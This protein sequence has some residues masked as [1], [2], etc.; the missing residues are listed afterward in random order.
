MH[1]YINRYFSLA[2]IPIIAAFFPYLAAHFFDSSQL[3]G[4]FSADTFFLLLLLQL[5]YGKIL[6]KMPLVVA[7]CI[8]AIITDSIDVYVTV[9]VFIVMIFVITFVPRTRKCLLPF[10]VIFSLLFIVADSGNFFYS[11]FVL[12]LPDVWNLA[13]FYWWGPVLFVVVPVSI[14]VL[15][16]LFVRRNLWGE[17]R[18]EIS[19][20][21]CY[22]LVVVALALNFGMN[23][24][25]D[26]QPIMD[27]AVK[28]WFWQVCTP[29]IIG[30]NT[31]LQEDTRANFSIWEKDVSVI[32]DFARPTVVVLVES[33]GVNKSVLYTKALLSSFENSNI[34]F[35][36]IYSREA[37]HTQGAE[38]EDF[39][40][41]GGVVRD[42]P[43][44]QKFKDHGLET[45]YIHGYDGSF[46]KRL[47]DYGKF[48]FDTLVF[49]KDLLNR[50][51]NNCAYG[52]Q[53]IC[54][55]AIIGFLDSLLTDSVP[56]FIYWTTLDAHPPYELTTLAEKAPE[57]SL[58][59]LS[60]VDCTYLTLQENTMKHLARLISKHDRYRFV[61]RGDH[62][63]MG[64]LEKTDFVQSFYFRWVPLIVVN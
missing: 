32:T 42:N 54:D 41:P 25:Q 35:L 49:K 12:T 43:I 30:Y 8:W 5:P 10:F 38:W 11:T 21:T 37:S 50:G 26:R 46:Y 29:G 33:F 40:T 36:G 53:G 52:F 13:R 3:H 7:G 55:S 19:H 60:D 24:L 63:P 27:F 20:L 17:S 31:F 15:Q 45:W 4:F 48:G 6:Y 59:D 39:G 62:R 2:I 56:K 28:K 47:D 51:L 58:L 22:I 1:K 9:A 61:I 16:V 34:R 57:C 18:F 44:P 14:V 64:A 23:K